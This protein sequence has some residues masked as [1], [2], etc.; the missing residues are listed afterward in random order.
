MPDQTCYECDLQDG[1]NNGNNGSMYWDSSPSCGLGLKLNW[2]E[3]WGWNNAYQG[4]AKAKRKVT[5]QRYWT[6]A[7]G[8]HYGVPDGDIIYDWETF[9]TEQALVNR[10]WY[11]IHLDRNSGN[12]QQYTVPV[13]AI[14]FWVKV[15]IELKIED[16]ANMDREDGCSWVTLPF[17]QWVGEL[18]RAATWPASW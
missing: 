16:P 8:Q 17:E 10:N 6:N 5:I 18:S 1:D 4:V 9:T 3:S 12:N 7:Y 13:G 14:S 15:L 11:L 2:K